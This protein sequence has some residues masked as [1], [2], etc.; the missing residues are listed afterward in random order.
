MVS[1]HIAELATDNVQ[2]DMHARAVPT[3]VE[4]PDHMHGGQEGI[5]GVVGAKGRTEENE[6][7]RGGGGGTVKGCE[8]E[9]FT[10]HKSS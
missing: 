10:A 4:F 7:G 1:G 9:E 3:L 8:G 5:L 2:L 6:K